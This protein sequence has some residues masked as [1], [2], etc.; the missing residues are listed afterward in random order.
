MIVRDIVS[1]KPRNDNNKRLRALTSIRSQKNNK[2]MGRDRIKAD[3]TDRRFPIDP[4]GH[5]INQKSI[6]LT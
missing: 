6:P 5:S 3:E 1:I 4:W 2:R